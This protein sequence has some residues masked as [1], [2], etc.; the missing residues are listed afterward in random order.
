MSDQ[1]SDHVSDRAKTVLIVQHQPD[2]AEL[3]RAIFES[4]NCITV[5][6]PPQT[7]IMA[8]VTEISPDLLV[9]DITSG[10]FNPFA[11]CRECRSQF[12]H[13]PLLLTHQVGRAIEAAERRWAL[14]Q[15][16]TDMISGLA[17]SEEAIQATDQVF[18]MTGW[19]RTVD[20]EALQTQLQRLGMT[21]PPTDPGI[22]QPL[23]PEPKPDPVLP[24]P[25]PAT[26]GHQKSNGSSP[27]GS[28]KLQVL[29]RGR[30]LHKP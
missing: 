11:L 4:Q 21:L 28:L 26:N 22:A 25:E 7:Q 20:I 6:A 29:Y 13:L 19:G 2:Q 15:G 9:A 10:V 23:D 17:S 27:G 8:L 1:V 14:Y 5:T 24:H 16:A 12:P 3:W 18:A 30:P